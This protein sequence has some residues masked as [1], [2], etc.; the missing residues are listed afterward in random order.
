MCYVL[1]SDKVTLTQQLLCMMT[2]PGTC[3]GQVTSMLQGQLAVTA[4]DPDGKLL[5]GT[6]TMPRWLHHNSHTHALCLAVPQLSH[7][8]IN[9]QVCAALQLGVK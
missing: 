8:V 7:R 6:G 2:K 4:Q 3:Y 1:G 5:A 9:F